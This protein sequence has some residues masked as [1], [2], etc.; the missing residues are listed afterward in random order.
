M[1]FCD[2]KAEFS[3]VITLLYLKIHRHY[4][5]HSETIQIH[6]LNAEETCFF[7]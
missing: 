4:S 2:C 7:S 5:D 3:T 6:S 1:Y